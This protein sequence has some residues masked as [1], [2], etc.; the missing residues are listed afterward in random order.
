MPADCCYLGEHTAL[1]RLKTGRKMYVDTRDTIVAPHL[2]LDGEW[3]KWVTEIVWRNLRPGDT[4]VDVGAHLGWYTLLAAERVGPRGCVVAFEPNDGLIAMLK[5]SLSIN[6]LDAEVLRLAASDRDG[7]VEFRTH[8]IYSGWGHVA[9]ADVPE[10]KVAACSNFLRSAPSMT[11]TSALRSYDRVHLVK[12]DAEHHEMAIL[13]GARSLVERCKPMLIVE[14]HP[15]AQPEE[16]AWLL[17]RGYT[18]AAIEHDSTLTKLELSE[19][20]KVLD[21]EMLLLTPPKAQ[22]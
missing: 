2:L 9:A 17:E 6:G 11:L 7:F 3:E 19:L 8:P 14:H 4:F 15:K 10:E 12:I 18:L 20:E 5:H 13:R 16:I 21:G 1:V 22:P